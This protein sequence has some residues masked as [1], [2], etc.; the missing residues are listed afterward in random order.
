MVFLPVALANLV[1]MPRKPDHRQKA[2]E[3]AGNTIRDM[4]CTMHDEPAFLLRYRTVEAVQ[5]PR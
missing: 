4:W 2:V 5:R 3:I 1:P